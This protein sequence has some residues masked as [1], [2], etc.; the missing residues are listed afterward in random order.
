MRIIAGDKRDT[1]LKFPC[2]FPLQS[3]VEAQK[4]AAT[5]VGS[6]DA[7]GPVDESLMGRKRFPLEMNPIERLEHLCDDRRA[8]VK[9]AAKAT[10]VSQDGV[11]LNGDKDADIVV[12]LKLQDGGKVLRP[13][14]SEFYFR[15]KLLLRPYGYHWSGA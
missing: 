12:R 3:L 13:R 14:A 9:V 10:Q 15:H 11:R 1:R 5:A 8:V 7:H 2:R 6:V 4:Q